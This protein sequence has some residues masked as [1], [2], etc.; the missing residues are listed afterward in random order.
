MLTERERMLLLDAA[1]PLAKLAFGLLLVLSPFRARIDLLAR[2][3]PP[4][5][6]DYTNFLLFWSDLAALLTLALWAVTLWARHGWRSVSLGP[7]F[8][9]VPI[10]GL[11][12]LGWIGIPFAVDPGL[13]AYTAIRLTV[14]AALA[15]YVLNEFEGLAQLRVPLA[16]MVGIQA[17]VAIAQVSAGHS[18]GLEGLGEHTL[19]PSM[20][21]SVVTAAD[22]SR[23]VRGYG[24]T[25]HPNILG[26]LLAFAS[27]L[28]VVAPGRDD[29]GG[30]VWAKVLFAAGAAAV[31]LTF[32]RSAGLALGVG[33][34]V[35][36]GMLV[37]RRAA[38]RGAVRHLVGAAALAAVV[39]LPFALAYGPYVLARSDLFG[40]IETEA[41]SL[42]EREALT[43]AANDVFLDHPILGVGL[44]GLP[45]A[46]RDAQ[47][48]FEYPYQPAH[49][50]LLD[51]AAETGAIG[52]LLYLAIL[53]TPWLAL[54]RQRPRWTPD[55]AAMSAALAALSVV[56]M[57]DYYTWSYPAGRIWTWVVLA[58]WA[59]AYRRATARVSATERP[60]PLSG[61]TA[62]AAGA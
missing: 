47:P 41:R 50:V 26:G 49:V 32:S 38:D 39:C 9:S 53:V 2:P 52:A 22:G 21:V 13:A 35:L 27:L 5:Y 62:E 61:L 25:D 48:Q 54:A 34:A 42:S 46:I 56:G 33:F 18:V 17:V 15:L 31:L 24:L 14:L 12:G 30:R 7:P 29:P 3:T 20:A 1:R 36:A 57:F 58:L 40:D 60:S 28:L 44:G 19:D 59:A 37:A 11:L 6:G 10:A 45:Q 23:V 16:A 43:I 4:L 8:L 51:V 55:L